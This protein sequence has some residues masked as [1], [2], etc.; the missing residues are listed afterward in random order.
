[1]ILEA[2]GSHTGGPRCVAASAT[3]GGTRE[4]RRAA[5]SPVPSSPPTP[6]PRVAWVGGRSGPGWTGDLGDGPHGET[7]HF[8]AQLLDRS[9]DRSSNPGSSRGRRPVH[10]D[11][12]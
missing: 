10:T 8:E 12:E 1:M 7:P 11:P 3:S 4:S 9:L 2:R 5:Q 6:D